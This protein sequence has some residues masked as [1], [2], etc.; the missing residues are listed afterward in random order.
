LVL[1]DESEKETKEGQELPQLLRSK[2]LTKPFEGGAEPSALPF[3]KRRNT[4]IYGSHSEP[5]LL[6]PGLAVA[7]G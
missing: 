2:E 5:V 6:F 4:Q 7:L 1:C 3:C